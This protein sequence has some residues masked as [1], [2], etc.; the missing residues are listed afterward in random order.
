MPI[1]YIVI[2]L[3]AW[4]LMIFAGMAAAADAPHNAAE[5]MGCDNCHQMHIQ[6]GN[7]QG[8]SLTKNSNANLCMNNCHASGGKAS[9]WPFTSTDQ[10]T[11][12]LSGTSHRWDGTMPATSSPN[13]PYGL[14]AAADIK[15]ATIKTELNKFGTCSNTAYSTQSTC[16]SNSGIWTSSVVCSTCHQQHSQSLTPYDPYSFNASKGDAGIVGGISGVVLTDGSSP[17]KTWTSNYWAGYVVVMT[18]GSGVGLSRPIVSNTGNTLT[19]SL[20]FPAGSVAQND[21]YYIVKNGSSF[22]SGTATGGSGT[23]LTD[24]TKTWTT[25]WTGYYV[26]MTGG[27]CSNQRRK[28]AACDLNAKTLTVEAFD[29]CS[30]AAGDTYYITSGR[31]FMRASNALADMCVDCHYYRSAAVSQTNVETWDGNKKSHPVGR[32][33]NQY[34]AANNPNGVRDAT[35]FNSA[36]L[37]PASKSWAAQTGTRYEQNSIGYCSDGISNSQSA[38]VTAG[39]TWYP[40]NWN[41]TSNISVGIDGKV[42]CLS[43]HNIHYSDSDSNTVDVPQGGHAP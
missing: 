39:A 11:P 40:A 29:S 30:V 43:C 24:N 36:P 5:G 34:D 23:T 31:H 22:D 14:R 25:D 17:S 3:T 41:I 4:S 8:A 21:N 10:A 13:N 20:A 7:S 37:E 18:S 26:K 42:N 16:V 27:L 2:G 6:L 33:L 9:N 12:G 15:T 32:N 38:C 28:I 1:K 35:Q 19:L